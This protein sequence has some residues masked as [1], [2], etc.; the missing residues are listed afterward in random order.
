MNQVVDA[1]DV[2]TFLL[3]HSEEEAKVLALS[4]AAELNLRAADIV[5]LEFNGFGARLRLRSYA[6]RPGDHYPWLENPEAACG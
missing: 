4:L 1:I 2:E 5:F 3:C 6:H